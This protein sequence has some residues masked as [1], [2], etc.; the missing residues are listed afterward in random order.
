MQDK[1]CVCE[2]TENKICE[3]NSVTTQHLPKC[4]SCTECN[5]NP[6]VCKCDC[7]IVPTR[8]PHT[9]PTLIFKNKGQGDMTLI[10][11]FE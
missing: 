7:H 2:D 6:S 11:D 1:L 3:C 8:D 4:D 10:R 5:C 9:D